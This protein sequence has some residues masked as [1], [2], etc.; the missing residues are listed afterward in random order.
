M[1]I[2]LSA[3]MCHAPIVVPAVGKDRGSLCEKTTAAMR[4]I[5]SRIA[6]S[7]P[8]VLVLLSPHAPRRPGQLGLVEGERLWGD[9]G[10]FGAPE[11]SV[12]LPAARDLRGALLSRRDLAGPIPARPLDHGALVP[13]WF[14]AE[15]GYR[16]PTLVAALPWE[17]QA[18]QLRAMGQAVARACEGLRAA[19]IAS[20]D[21]S[22]RL[23]PGAPAGYHPRAASF[24]QEV[25]M[26][27]SSGRPGDLREI[28]PDLRELAAEDVVASVLV[29]VSAAGDRADGCELLCYEGPFGVGYAEAVLF[30]DGSP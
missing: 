15:A 26:R 27:L 1:P 30:S 28:D 2:G 29:A 17:E 18:E 12:D 9:F 11:A 3:L 19:F 23:V 22:H 16:G 7:Q 14:V 13:L 8:D 20:G 10:S 6:R 5:A 25:V 24:D 21:M 4:A